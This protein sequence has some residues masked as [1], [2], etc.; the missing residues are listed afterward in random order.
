MEK[1]ITI[2]TGVGLN[3]IFP[4]YITIVIPQEEIKV[5]EEMVDSVK[6]IE[7]KNK[8]TKI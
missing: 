7:R 2:C 3:Q 8:K 4:E 5:D 6:K 1:T